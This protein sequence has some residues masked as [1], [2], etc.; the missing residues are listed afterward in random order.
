MDR[1]PYGYLITVP[2]NAFHIIKQK[3]EHFPRPGWCGED[4]RDYIMQ[5]R[6]SPILLKFFD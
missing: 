3:P 2:S 6:P 4:L 5:D 1:S